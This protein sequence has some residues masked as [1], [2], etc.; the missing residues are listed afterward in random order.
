MEKFEK[1]QKIDRRKKK[2]QE[3]AEAIS[4]LK[5]KWSI[6]ENNRIY[7]ISIFFLCLHID[8][9]DNLDYV[10]SHFTYENKKF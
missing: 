8:V 7:Y 5:F 9:K 4:G 10:A 1:R 3:S 2:E 6:K